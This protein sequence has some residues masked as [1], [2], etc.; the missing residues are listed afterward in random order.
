MPNIQPFPNEASRAKVKELIDRLRDGPPPVDG[1]LRQKL[2]L[3]PLGGD[4]VIMSLPLYR[5]ILVMLEEG[6]LEH[7]VY[8]AEM[9]KTAFDAPFQP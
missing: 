4:D 1:S 6:T 2:G 5:L 3:Y 7:R 8:V 9:L